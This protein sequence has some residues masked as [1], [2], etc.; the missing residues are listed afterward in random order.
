MYKAR[1]AAMK[2]RDLNTM[3]EDRCTKHHFQ[4]NKAKATATQIAAIQCKQTGIIHTTQAKIEETMNASWS[5]VFKERI[6]NEEAI[7][8]ILSYIDKTLTDSESEKIGS[9]ITIEELKE[10]IQLAKLH[11]SPGLDGLPSDFYYFFRNEQDELIIK[12]MHKVFIQSQI[13]G[14]LPKSM[15]KI[16]IRCYLKKRQI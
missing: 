8:K 4:L 3:E 12:F 10:A 9:P 13:N 2:A 5:Q 11:K 14:I 15:R 16:Q 1:A 7:K 6:T